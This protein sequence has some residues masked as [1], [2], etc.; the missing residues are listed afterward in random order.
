VEASDT[1]SW[2]WDLRKVAEPAS[3][4]IL[5]ADADND[6]DS[7]W[8]DTVVQVTEDKR[9]FQVRCMERAVEGSFLAL[10]LRPAV[11]SSDLAAMT[12]ESALQMQ[13]VAVERKEMAPKLQSA[14]SELADSEMSLEIAG[15]TDCC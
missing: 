1:D 8:A 7:C 3:V 13:A 5:A 12:V 10:V 11:D 9:Q 2:D 4:D 15:S 6:V 14:A